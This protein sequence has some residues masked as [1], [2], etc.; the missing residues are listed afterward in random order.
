MSEPKY[1]ECPYCGRSLTADHKCW[2]SVTIPSIIEHVDDPATLRA[3]ISRL[4]SELAEAKKRQHMSDLNYDAEI[5]RAEKAE[6]SLHKSQA[7]VARLIEFVELFKDETCVNASRI[8]GVCTACLAKQ[9][10]AEIK[11]KG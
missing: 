1:G 5:R 7:R 8:K 2:Q 10:L 9:V 4:Q 3:E 11:E 6:A